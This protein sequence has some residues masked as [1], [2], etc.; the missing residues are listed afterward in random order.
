[1]SLFTSTARV[2]AAAL[3]VPAALVAGAPS[4]QAADLNV[5]CVGAP[6]GV[7]CD[8]TAATINAATAGLQ[9]NGLDDLIAVG[10]GTYEEAA[11]ITLQGG[12]N[13]LTL[14][15]SG[16]STIVTLAEESPATTY[17]FATNA[18]VRDLNVDLLPGSGQWAV[19]IANGAV[20]DV[21]ISGPSSTS[22]IGLLMQ[23]STAVDV[24]VALPANSGRGIYLI[25][26]AQVSDAVVTAGTGV[27]AG[28]SSGI[29]RVT[30]A[31]IRANALGVSV[32]EGDLTV[33]NTVI[34]L[35]TSSGSGLRAGTTTPGTGS[36]F[37]TADHV[38]VVGGG[39]NSEG[40]HAFANVPTAR[41]SAT[42][43]VSNSVLSGQAFPIA[44]YAENDGN[45]G[46]S[47]EAFVQITHSDFDAEAIDAGIGPNGTGGISIG[48]GNIDAAP[49][50]TDPATGNY[51][52][53]PG[54]P[55]I[56]AGNP[57]AGTSTLD[58]VGNPRVADGN[59]DITAVR[60]MGAY[61]V[62]DT[63]A[64]QTSGVGGPTSP[65]RDRTPT[66]TFS[67]EPGAAFTCRIDART[68]VPCS[69]PFTSPSLADGT[70][71]ITV[72][73]R[74]ALG[75]ADPTPST[76]TFVI[77]NVAPNTRFLAKPASTIRMSTA[78]FRFAAPGAVRFQCKLDARPWRACTSPK[79]FSVAKGRHVVRV[80]GIDR[81]GNV[82]PT[83]ALHRFKR[84]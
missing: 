32:E 34:D 66:F 73:A 17:V 59:G 10:P 23:D 30:R 19:N 35:G 84:V 8:S 49:Q 57:A 29:Q 6:V 31:R 25:G 7:T 24:S 45:Q 64:A 14:Q 15:G 65:F 16:P 44:T 1:M 70:H 62:P 2:V 83:P 58:L 3:V 43:L 61:E 76:R 77:D 50:F 71:K 22:A 53:A 28:Q 20:S 12:A 72:T 52:P 55:L 9:A 82:D 38:T 51:R 79:V 18:D 40:A 75:N 56:D 27:D 80:R 36:A 74:D 33:D 42:I 81:A 39:G 68:P 26:D 48:A 69:S 13:E 46:G 60:D 4:A 11:T 78:R 54:S 37:I 41:R 5:V 47:S 67:S 21:A 63:F